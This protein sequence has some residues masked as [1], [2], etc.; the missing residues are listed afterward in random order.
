RRASMHGGRATRTQL[1]SYPAPRQRATA[2][3]GVSVP[4]KIPECVKVGDVPGLRML[5]VSSDD[6]MNCRKRESARATSTIDFSSTHELYWRAVSS[7]V[8]ALSTTSCS[9]ALV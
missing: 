5:P 4:W 7:S 3:V 2:P 8:L 6:G 9:H 1:S